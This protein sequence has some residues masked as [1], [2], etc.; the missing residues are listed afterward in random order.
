MAVL[1]VTGRLAGDVWQPIR[2]VSS[3]PATEEI[4]VLQT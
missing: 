3:T 2:A 4:A 1:D